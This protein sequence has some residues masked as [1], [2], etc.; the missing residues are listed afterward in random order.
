MPIRQYMQYF[1]HIIKESAEV[2]L[3]SLRRWKSGRPPSDLVPLFAQIRTSG[4]AVVERFW[5]AE[6]CA[7][8]V[9]EIEGALA[10]EQTKYHRWTDIEGADNRIY[11]AERA[12][13]E[14]A[15]FHNDAN[16]EKIRRYY[17]GVARADTLL[18]AARLAY[19]P[20]NT[21]SGGGWHRDSPHRSQFKAILYLSDVSVK[22]GPFEY[23]EGTHLASRSL[24]L[25]FERQCRPNQ[26][27][28][29]NAEADGMLAA[30]LRCDTLT[31]A[32]GTLI[33]VDSKGIHRGRPIE[34]GNR[35][36]LT[37]YCFDGM[38]PPDFA[39]SFK[40]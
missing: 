5:P 8:A 19:V 21:G 14:L 35:Y 36:A 2:V 29:S 33:L 3:R 7:L 9:Q 6:R 4:Y 30:G 10:D 27:R 13:G 26:Y 20:G 38:R 24:R 15:N 37:Q 28:F 25:L 16:I 18:L 11:F 40:T 34:R 17:S 12:G 32:A 1:E 39:A 23:I 22:N 31:G